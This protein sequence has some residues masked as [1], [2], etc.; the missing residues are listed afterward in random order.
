MSPTLDLAEVDFDELR[1]V[2]RQARDFDFVELV[3]DD[4]A[5]GLA[6][7]RLFL[8]EEVQRHADAD[9]LVLVDAQEVHVQH[10]LLERMPLH[11]AQQDLLHLAV[12]VQVEDRRVEPLVLA[13]EPDVVVLELDGLRSARRRRRWPGRCPRDA[14][15]GSHPCPRLALVPLM[16]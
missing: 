5:R 1:Q 11:V 7:R 12:D 14:G 10:L 13:R 9:R 15:G 16:L 2:L 4:H 8:V 3:R 6:G